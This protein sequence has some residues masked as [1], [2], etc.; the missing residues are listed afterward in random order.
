VGSSALMAFGP[1]SLWNKALVL[2]PLAIGLNVCVGVGWILAT[3]EYVAELDEL[4]RKIYLNALA[5]TVGVA[6]IAG[7]PFSVMDKYALIPF[8]AH[9]WHLLMLMSVTFSASFLHGTWRYR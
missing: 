4:Q 6:L 2:T 3:K 8:H 5:I 7:V 1:N 9:I